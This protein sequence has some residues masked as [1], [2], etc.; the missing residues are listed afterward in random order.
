M[1]IFLYKIKKINIF[2]IFLIFFNCSYTDFAKI[3]TAQEEGLVALKRT[4]SSEFLLRSTKKETLKFAISYEELTLK[5]KKKEGVNIIDVRNSDSFE[6][7]RIPGSINM[8]LFSIK[9]KDYLKS[10]E[11]VFVN[12]GSN[13][14]QVVQECENLKKLGFNNLYILQGGLNYWRQKGGEVEGDVFALMNLNKISSQDFFEE[15]D[16]DNW[17]AIDISDS[18][19]SEADYLI[20]ERIHIPYKNNPERFVAQVKAKVKENKTNTFNN[21]V[22][23]D[24]DGE[25][26]KSVEMH[27]S[28]QEPGNM[29]YLKG[30]LKEYKSFLQKQTLLMQSKTNNKITVEKC[31]TC[32]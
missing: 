8:P 5:I 17:I 10:G 16:Y 32:P 28:G 21:V 4:I 30:G 31:S 6:K 20:P 13:Y 22:I 29:F 14:S 11:L 1:S 7:F 24:E 15:K 26:Y 19:N 18:K 27:L 25:K 12:E 9:T 3:S 23:F 2:S